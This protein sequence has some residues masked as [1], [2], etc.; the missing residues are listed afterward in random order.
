MKKTVFNI[1]KMD[2]P[3]E[4]R[5][6]KMSL[7]QVETI[8][9]LEFDLQGHRL[10]I[11]HLGEAEKLLILLKPLGFGAEI[12]SSEDFEEDFKI[13]TSPDVNPDIAETSVLKIALIINA[14]MFF[15]GLIAGLIAESTG[16]IADSLD[17]FA[18]AA[19]QLM[20]LLKQ[21]MTLFCTGEDVSADA[22]CPSIKSP[23]TAHANIRYHA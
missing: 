6:V 4:E 16:L 2:C 15:I 10:S 22:F 3:T 19:V 20:I 14:T 17:M 1:P 8:E 5:L 21:Y 12:I 18:D 7:Q 11:L 9:K 23:L 13:L